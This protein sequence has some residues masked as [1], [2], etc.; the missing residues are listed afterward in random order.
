MEN[1]IYLSVRIAA[2]IYLS[3]RLW[4]LLFGRK[5]HALWDTL[6]YQARMA[7]VRWWSYRKK[8]LAEKEERDRRRA[9]RTGRRQR[10]AV[11]TGEKPDS[12]AGQTPAGSNHE[13]I[14]KTRIVYLED[15]EKARKTPVRSEPLPPSDYI[16]EEEDIDTD[17]VEDN[18]ADAT[19][20]RPALTDKEKQEL[21]APVEAEPDPD[22][23]TALTFEQL[24]NVAEVLTTASGDEQKK[25]QAAELLY[26]LQ[27]TD[28]FN[29]FSTELGNREDIERLFKECLDGKGRPRKQV[30]GEGTSGKID[31]NSY[32]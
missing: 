5:A 17:D 24:G 4:L 30:Q 13:V 27:D 7:R 22:F 28:L 19:P 2:A 26:Q 21:M 29:F 9:R 23:S 10:Q 16:G 12:R 31:W 15:P 6:H 32:M 1:S 25:M 3:Y 11:K 18:L 20:H 8:R 14:G